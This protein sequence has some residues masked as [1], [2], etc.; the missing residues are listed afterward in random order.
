MWLYVG[1]TIFHKLEQGSGKHFFPKEYTFDMEEILSVFQFSYFVFFPA[2]VIRVPFS[3][4]HK[5]NLVD[6]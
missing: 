1:A 6:L 2:R 3:Y 4:I 5:K